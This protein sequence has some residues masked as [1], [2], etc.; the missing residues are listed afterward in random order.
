MA[1]LI[2]DATSGTI[3]NMGDCYIVDSQHLGDDLVYSD[4]EI[5]EIA[6][7]H[8]IYIAD[9]ARDTGFGDNKYRFTV[10]YSPLSLRD[11]A[12][13]LIDGGI[14]GED[15]EEY[16]FLAWAGQDATDE[17]LAELADYIMADDSVWD[18][19]KSHVIDGLRGYFADIKEK[20]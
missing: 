5:G 8:G 20:K 13:T 19:F 11:E 9:M 18:G 12:N 10:S 3:L 7:K 14:F 6:E 16:Q 17:E 4:S 1:K 15:E 2:I